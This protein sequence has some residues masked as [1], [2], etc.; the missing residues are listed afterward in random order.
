MGGSRDWYSAPGRRT[1]GKQTSYFEFLIPEFSKRNSFTPGLYASLHALDVQDLGFRFRLEL[2]GGRRSAEAVPSNYVRMAYA[3]PHFETPAK[4]IQLEQLDI[5]SSTGEQIHRL[6][7]E[8]RL[9]LS[10]QNLYAYDDSERWFLHVGKQIIALDALPGTPAVLDNWKGPRRSYWMLQ[11]FVVDVK[12]QAVLSGFDEKGA[13]SI[14]NRLAP[15]AGN[16]RLA[17]WHD[18]SIRQMRNIGQSLRD[19]YDLR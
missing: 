17:E 10:L 9:L 2:W 5:A 8:G 16:A 12:V 14:L 19:N 13:V 4:A 18:V 11:A 7:D 15:V 6:S 3:F 1:H